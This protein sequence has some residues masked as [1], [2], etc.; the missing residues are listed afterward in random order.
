[1]IKLTVSALSAA[2]LLSPVALAESWDNVG[3]LV[4]DPS[5]EV[6]SAMLAIDATREVIDEASAA[7]CELIVAYHPVIFDGLT[8]QATIDSAPEAIWAAAASTAAFISS[9]TSAAL[10]SSRA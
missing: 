10:F 1:M 8:V 2:V 7:G 3:L 4:G 9:L 6:R 5:Q